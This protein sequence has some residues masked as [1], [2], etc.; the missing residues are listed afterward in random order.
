MYIFK[1][2]EPVNVISINNEINKNNNIKSILTKYLY[3][4]PMISFRQFKLYAEKEIKN[5][6]L[7]IA[8]YENNLKIFIIHLEIIQI[9]LNGHLYFL[10]IRQKIIKF[11]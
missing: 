1:K 6:K 5:I 4:N 10:I 7:K 3:N 11:I 9:F 2:P 8:F